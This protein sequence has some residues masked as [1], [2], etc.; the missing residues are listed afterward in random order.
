MCVAL[1]PPEIVAAM[2]CGTWLT[3]CALSLGPAPDWAWPRLQ[4]QLQ[5]RL[6]LR[7]RR[8]HLC[9]LVFG[10]QVHGQH[11]AT[12]ECIH[13][14]ATHC[15]TS[16]QTSSDSLLA[17]HLIKRYIFS[18]P[19]QLSQPCYVMLSSLCLI[20]FPTAALSTYFAPS[21]PR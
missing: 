17:K 12:H 15:R 2:W 13:C 11:W 8:L 1:G 21:Y 10:T 20:G 14:I 9:N 4:L 5:L 6:R 16:K 7:L 19:G 3:S 18:S